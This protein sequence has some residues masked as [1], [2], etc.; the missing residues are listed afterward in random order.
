VVVGAKRGRDDD[1]DAK[2][3]PRFRGDGN[4]SDE[5]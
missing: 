1:G 4:D 5:D 3:N 2:E